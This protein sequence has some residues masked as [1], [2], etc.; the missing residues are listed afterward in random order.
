MNDTAY[1]VFRPLY[2]TLCAIDPRVSLWTDT[3]IAEDPIYA[4]ASILARL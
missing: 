3:L 4:R 2:D 1:I